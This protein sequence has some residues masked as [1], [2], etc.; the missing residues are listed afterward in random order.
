M[1]LL[2]AIFP[3]TIGDKLIGYDNHSWKFILHYASWYLFV[4][5]FIFYSWQRQSEIKRNPTVFDFGKYS[6]SSGVIHPFFINWGTKRLSN[7]TANIRDYSAPLD[8]IAGTHF[9]GTDSATDVL[10]ERK[11]R[12]NKTDE[13]QQAETNYRKIETLLEPAFF[14]L[15]GFGLNILGQYIGFILIF[16]SIFYSLGYLCAYKMGDDFVMDK[17]DEMIMNEELES[18]FVNEKNAD[19]TRGVRFYAQKPNSKSDRRKVADSFLEQDEWAS[20]EV[21]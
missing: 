10:K 19:Q 16:C 20:V 7:I 15:L 12:K 14:F 6:L 5:A 11:I 4:I 3:V 17:I 1:A 8:T 13:L 2:L 18:A 21:K 9:Y